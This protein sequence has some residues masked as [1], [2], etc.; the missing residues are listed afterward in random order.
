MI[1]ADLWQRLCEVRRTSCGY[2]ASQG[3]PNRCYCLD[4]DCPC[5]SIGFEEVHGEPLWF[6]GLSY[7]DSYNKVA[8]KAPS[9]TLLLAEAEKAG[10]DWEY[11]PMFGYIFYK[12]DN[13]PADIIYVTAWTAVIE[14]THSSIMLSSGLLSC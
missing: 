13:R 10:F 8:P 4:G 1:K 6:L 11:D 7:N 14:L 5:H 9:M 12:S 3:W 2:F